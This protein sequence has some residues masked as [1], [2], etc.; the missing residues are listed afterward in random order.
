MNLKGVFF[1]ISYK[2]EKK[3]YNN[4]QNFL[5]AFKNIF[6]IDFLFESPLVKIFKMMRIPPSLTVGFKTNIIFFVR[7]FV[8]IQHVEK[9][10]IK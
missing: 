9:K 8:T 4:S 5:R 6:K 7:F 2:L 10:E 3:T 1:K